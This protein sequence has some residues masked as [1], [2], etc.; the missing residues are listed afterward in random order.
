MDEQ[1]HLPDVFKFTGTAEGLQET[2]KWVMQRGIFGQ[3]RGPGLRTL[4]IPSP[5]PQHKTNVSSVMKY[6]ELW[7]AL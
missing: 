7:G 4:A 1:E 6:W 3:F 5:S 2:T